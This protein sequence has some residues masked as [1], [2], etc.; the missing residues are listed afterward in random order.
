MNL[1]PQ[2]EASNIQRLDAAILPLLQ[3]VR[4]RPVVLADG[5]RTLS[6]LD[7]SRLFLQQA[8]MDPQPIQDRFKRDGYC[9]SAFRYHAEVHLGLSAS[10]FEQVGTAVAREAPLYPGAAGFLRRAAEEAAVFVISAGIPRIWRGLLDREGL[11]HIGVIG[12]INPA[13]PYVFGREE[14]GWVCQR[15][16]SIATEVMA[17]GDSDV[18]TEMMLAANHAVVVLNHRMSADLLSHLDDHHSLHHIA[19]AGQPVPG[20]SQLTFESAHR[21]ICRGR[22]D[23]ERGTACR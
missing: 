8:G 3:A 14:K 18:D 5:D 2:D 7:T 6:P 20:I 22:S 12:G 10:T 4:G 16:R 13:L 21:L 9:F 15:F 19:P 11:G 17:L 23:T 1:L